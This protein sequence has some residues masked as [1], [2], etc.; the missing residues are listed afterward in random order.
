MEVKVAD[1]EEAVAILEQDYLRSTGLS[2]HELSSAD[3]VFDESALTTVCPACNT[4]FVPQES[5]VCPEC[6]L[7]FG[8]TLG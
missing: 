3:A 6:G 4:S 2:H 8:E 7:S 5:S 1:A